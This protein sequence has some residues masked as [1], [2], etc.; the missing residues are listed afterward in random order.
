MAFRK[1]LNHPSANLIIKKLTNGAGVRQVA[2]MLK[3]MYP[4]DKKLHI[5]FPML[6]KFRKEHLN[7]EGDAL[8]VIK[9][10]TKEQKEIETQKKEHSQLK[11]MTSY[12][13]KL[14]EAMNLHIDV[15]T[16]LATLHTLMMSRTEALFDK[17][18]A[19]DGTK[20]DEEHLQK[21]FQTYITV[22]ER[23]SKY[24]DK[25]ADYTTETNINVTVIEDQMALLREAVWEIIREMDPLLAVRFLEKLDNKMKNFQ[26]RQDRKMTLREAHEDVKV[27][28]AQIIGPDGEEND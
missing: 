12:K 25:V 16:Q 11:K 27:I 7:I 17:L 22:L 8:E 20:S 23:W 5:S 4:K 24:I 28:T 3:E 15:K 6:Q 10:V 14:Q 19:G 9:E 26:Y 1:I 2:N 21:Y 18:S 13:E